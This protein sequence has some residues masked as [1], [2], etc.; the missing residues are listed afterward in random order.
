MKRLLILS[1][2]A[3]HALA[4]QTPTAIDAQNVIAAAQATLVP[5]QTITG[6][7][8]TVCQLSKVPGASISGWFACTLGKQSLRPVTFQSTSPTGIPIYIGMGKAFGWVMV[9]NTPTAG[10]SW[11]FA[12][13]DGATILTG[14]VAWP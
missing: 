13:G 14:S 2:F 12:N 3:V 10:I 9:G 4:A 7:D 8:G 6:T 11:Q 1:I 5:L